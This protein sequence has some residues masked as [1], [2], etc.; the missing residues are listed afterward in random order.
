MREQMHSYVLCVSYVFSVTDFTFS[1]DDFYN[2]FVFILYIWLFC[3]YVCVCM[4]V[5]EPLE[6]KKGIRFPE[7]GVM[8]DYKLPWGC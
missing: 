7:I 3:L 6:S 1:S 8:N 4:W 5:Q 2:V